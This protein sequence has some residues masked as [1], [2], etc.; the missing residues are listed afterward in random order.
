MFRVDDGAHGNLY[1]DGFG[2]Y[3]VVD[4]GRVDNNEGSSGGI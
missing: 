1:R 2:R 3:F 4:D